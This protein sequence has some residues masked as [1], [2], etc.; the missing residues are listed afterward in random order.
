MKLTIGV[1]AD[2][3]HETDGIDE[4]EHAESAYEFASTHGGSGLFGKNTPPA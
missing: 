2:P 3:Q 4:H 1:R